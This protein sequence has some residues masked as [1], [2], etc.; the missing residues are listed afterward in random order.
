MSDGRMDGVRA[1]EPNGPRVRIRAGW[2]DEGLLG[3]VIGAQVLLGQWWCPVLWDGEEDPDWNKSA[4]LELAGDEA[5]ALRRETEAAEEKARAL[6][7]QLDAA[8]LA[9][10]K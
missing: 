10:A 1:D 6:R 7:G 2:L 8:L 9:K 4:G 5:A 3:T